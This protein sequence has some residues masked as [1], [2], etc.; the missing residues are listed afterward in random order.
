SERADH[1]EQ[2][3]E[4]QAIQLGSAWQV[5]SWKPF[6]RLVSLTYD[7]VATK[8][9]ADEMQRFGETMPVYRVYARW[10]RAAYCV[11]RGNYAAALELFQDN[12]DEPAELLGQP[13]AHG[14][15]A[16]AYN[17]LG[18]YERARALCHDAIAHMSDG[19]R[20]IVYVSVRVE[21]ELALAEAG[22]GRCE[23]A[24]MQL[25]SLMRRHCPQTGPLVKGFLH[26]TQA[27]VALIEQDLDGY[28]SQLE[29]ASAE[30]GPLGIASLNEQLAALRHASKSHET[31]TLSTLEGAQIQLRTD[32]HFL[33]RMELILQSVG[34]S[35]KSERTNKALRLALELA[36]A[37]QGFVVNAEGTIIACI[38][39]PSAPAQAWALS[40]LSA[41]REDR[42]D[43]TVLALPAQVPTQA[44]HQ[45]G[46]EG[47]SFRLELLWRRGLHNAEPTAALVMGATGAEPRALPTDVLRTIAS[48][49]TELRVPGNDV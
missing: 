25:A 38:G 34:S 45:F 48:G 42:D 10:L 33:T 41:A 35:Q 23:V 21:A 11:L 18:Q 29:Y 8:R 19:N 47:V 17:G 24:R 32:G 20:K 46:F 6:L 2:Q 43:E 15:C 26:C 37:D 36:G 31:T 30:Y 39:E 16:A 1:Y 13:V 40:Q 22:L 44:T 12:A 28:R 14:W 9:A 3:V 27:R 49:L 5:E 7:A 4:L